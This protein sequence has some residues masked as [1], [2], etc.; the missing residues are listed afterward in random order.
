VGFFVF[1]ILVTL[2]LFL[3]NVC[4]LLLHKNREEMFRGIVT[5]ILLAVGLM[6]N[7]QMGIVR[8]KV[9][10]ADLGE[11]LIGAAVFIAGTSRGASADLEGNYTI[12]NLEPGKYNLVCQY[13]SFA[14][15]TI[16]GVVVQAD[17]VTVLDF[18]LG[19]SSISIAEFVV[20]AK[21]NK[22][23]ENFMLTMQKKS[24]GVMDGISSQQI[25]RSGDGNAAAAA[26]RITGVS[27]EG[28]KYVYVRG[29]SDR[30]SLTT[31]NEAEI[32][33]LD[34]ERN[35][36][37]LDLIPTNLID[38]MQVF[39]SFTPD[40]PASFTGGLVNIGTKDFP[41][42]ETFQFSTSF[43][44]NT[45]SSLNSDFIGGEK[46]GKFFTSFGKKKHEVPF[47]NRVYNLGENAAG[48]SAQS[49]A[50]S[51]EYVPTKTG[52]G[53]DHG[54]SVSYGNQKPLD[55]QGVKSLGYI[56]GITYN[57][58]YEFK[59]D[60]TIG[61]YKLTG[62][63]ETV[64]ELNREREYTGQEGQ[65]TVLLGA[66][67][68]LSYKYNANNKL[69]F[70][71]MVNR[72]ATNSARVFEGENTGADVGITQV[73]RKMQYQERSLVVFQ[74]IGE[75][76]RAKNNLTVKWMFSG[77]QSNQ[78]EPDLRYFISDYEINN[79][80]TTHDIQGAK[81]ALPTHF[82]RRMEERSYHGKLDVEKPM[83]L[84]EGLDGKVKAGASMVAKD[85]TFNTRSMVYS[86]STNLRARFNDDY[87]GDPEA[88]FVD[89]NM[90]VGDPDG[91]M[92][93]KDNTQRRNSY[94]G[95]SAI[96]AVYGMY[97]G[98]ITPIVRV[99]A[100]ARVEMT[101]IKV[102]SFDPEVRAGA[103]NNFDV[104]PAL[105]I[106]Y[107]L[108]EEQNIRFGYTKT[109]ARP[110]FREIAPFASFGGGSD[111]TVQGNPDLVRTNIDNLDLR[112]EYFMNPGEM[113]S[114]SAFGKRFV[115]PIERVFS[116][117]AVS[118]LTWS[119]VDN[120]KLYG[121]E[122][123][124]RKSL[125]C[126]SE[127]LQNWSAGGNVTLIKS[128]VD[129]SD[130]E[131]EFVRLKRP[132][133]GDTRQL[134]GQSPY[135]LNLFLNYNNSETGLKGN[136]SFNV[137]GEKIAI[138]GRKGDPH[139]YEQA[140]PTLDF[141]IGKV[142]KEKFSVKFAAKNLLGS[143]T[144]WLMHFKDQDYQVYGFNPGRTFSFGFSYFIN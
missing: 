131:L 126:I 128:V 137:S 82:W 25:A 85:R 140:R 62:S 139:V 3:R 106:S 42:R 103:L 91:Y 90:N 144:N 56:G 16:K 107:N 35:S 124:I 49:K 81:Y 67:A 55:E 135:I 46:A 109:L 134:F 72:D 127:S 138:V 71:F 132:S 65:E 63:E 117:E 29:L 74:G 18:N 92:Y 44:Y 129:L 30:Y 57:R 142:I 45:I 73:E 9:R 141:N 122:A 77:A 41:A 27:I 53:L 120:A 14:N 121:V 61:N 7:A 2:G 50:L 89:E 40:K 4:A 5:C 66:L 34:P 54:F 116:K 36:V 70:N 52:S 102:N 136:L 80:D 143:E 47:N 59:E 101:D 10:S 26:K 20:E 33:S 39:K 78:N 31:L 15:D 51:K 105:N 113:I 86:I 94:S 87:N 114:V 75:H 24:A 22:A 11:E 13:I 64:D 123:E 99:V 118:E 17:E 84:V 111:F 32:P 69:G 100:G 37:Q 88:F 95:T 96:S 119:N 112:W 79:G 133:A 43:G 83:Q 48:L 97:D 125:A 68:N 110:S 93:V 8:G 130:D 28:G 115:N 104:L 38:N 1:N 6:A 58:S 76:Y 12:L 23:S 19:S 98:Y 21:A 60:L 108:S